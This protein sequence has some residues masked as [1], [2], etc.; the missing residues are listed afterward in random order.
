MKKMLLYLR[1]V[2]MISVGEVH[3]GN[4]H[5]SSYELREHLKGLRLRANGANKFR[6][7]RAARWCERA[8]LL[9]VDGQIVLEG[10]AHAASV[11]GSSTQ[12][13]QQPRNYHIATR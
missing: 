12:H 8:L 7:H 3:A 10:G 4:I 5:A 9:E 2:R 13:H 1:M 6:V 11:C